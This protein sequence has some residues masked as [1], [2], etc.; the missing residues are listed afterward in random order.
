MSP[1]RV[2]TARVTLYA[3]S[4]KLSVQFVSIKKI[5]LSV[6]T[7]LPPMFDQ[8]S[9]HVIVLLV[10]AACRSKTQ[11]NARSVAGSLS[12]ITSGSHG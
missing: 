1:R 8:R 9:H 4:P 6:T 3:L 7:D 10:L 11:K 5:C 12:P 2:R